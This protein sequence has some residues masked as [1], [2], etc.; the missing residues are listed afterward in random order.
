MMEPYP[1][2]MADRMVKSVATA[3]PAI[4]QIV[5]QQACDNYAG[6]VSEVFFGLHSYRS[7]AGA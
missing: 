5:T 2:Y 6:D 4:R 7:E 1:I 3:L